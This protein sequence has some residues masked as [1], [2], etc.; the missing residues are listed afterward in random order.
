MRKVKSAFICVL[1]AVVLLAAL[2]MSAQAQTEADAV[3][4]K[5]ASDYQSA[6]AATG[7]ESLHGYCG[8]M[9]SWQLYLM[10]INSSLITADGNKQY[11]YYCQRRYTTGGHK[12]RA[13]S[14]EDY[15]LEEALYAA[16]DY[17]QTDAY[18]LL[19]GFE[20]TNTEAGAVY[21]HAVVIYAILDGMVYF[22]ESFDMPFGNA[23]GQAICLSIATFA[24][25]YDGWTVFEGLINFGKKDLTYT[26]DHY[27]VDYFCAAKETLTLYTQPCTGEPDGIQTKAVRVVPAR[28]RLHVTG[29]LQDDQGNWFYR[30]DDGGEDLYTQVDLLELVT[31]PQPTVEVKEVKLPERIDAGEKFTPQV[32]VTVDSQVPVELAVRLLNENRAAVGLYEMQEQN[33]VYYLPSGKMDLAALTEGVYTVQVMLFW[34]QNQWFEGA[35]ECWSQ[36]LVVMEQFFCVGQTAQLPAVAASTQPQ[37]DG[38]IYENSTWY[39]YKN[40]E[41]QTGWLCYEGIDYYLK[42]DGSITTGWA[43][44][45]GKDRFFSQTG[46][47]RTGWMDAAEGR[48]YFMCNGVPVKGFREIDGVRY[49]F[50]DDGLM[51]RNEWVEDGGYRYLIQR[52]GT[53]LCGGWFDTEEGRFFFHDTGEVLAQIVKENGKVRIQVIATME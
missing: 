3:R 10:G 24:Q 18:N 53:P 23:E 34:E 47:M 2:P 35:L 16:T 4:N 8:L 44:I 1:V 31:V 5:I 19:A 11:D 27:D 9:T 32:K 38:W 17:G 46:A 49:Y 42:E 52:D 25:Y 13:Y 29:L 36:E 21:G 22:T 15:T 6:L 51:V 43:Q 26:Y 20:Q 48:Y 37:Q 14:A 41:P 50:D 40:G 45:L 33:G 39:Y 7:M 30:V 12:I 28:E